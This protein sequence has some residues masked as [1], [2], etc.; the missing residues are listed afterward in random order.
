MLCNK[1]NNTDL[2]A[3]GSTIPEIEG[4]AGGSVAHSWSDYKKK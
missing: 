3:F 1:Q 2:L 4:L